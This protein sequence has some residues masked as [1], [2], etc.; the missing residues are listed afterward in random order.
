MERGPNHVIVDPAGGFPVISLVNLWLTLRDGL[1]LIL[2]IW[3]SV[4]ALAIAYAVLKTPEYRATAQLAYVSEDGAASGLLSSLQS[5]FGGLA[6]LAGV[7]VGGS[8]G[9]SKEE[10]IALLTS[11][12]LL[13]AFVSENDLLPVLFKGS[14]D[15]EAKAWSVAGEDVPTLEDAYLL[16]TEK[17]LKV[18]VDSKT[19]LI[20]VTVQWTDRDVAARWANELVRRANEH[21]RGQVIDDAQRSIEYLTAEI[22]QTSSVEVKSGLYNLIQSQINRTTLAKAREDFAFKVV[23]PAMAPD[24]DRIAVP[25]RLLVA[26]IGF[27]FGAFVGTGAVL[28][29]D[30]ARTFR[31]VVG[32]AERAGA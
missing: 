6:S 20:S 18:Q 4:F 5:Q 11:R 26:L 10:A 8:G 31:R 27:L 7:N 32:D 16:L 23:D 2:A 14:W 13:Q 9:T 3:M 15:A 19:S 22:A 24:A 1:R 25:N 28:L 12:T 21:L 29:R 30:I 17:L